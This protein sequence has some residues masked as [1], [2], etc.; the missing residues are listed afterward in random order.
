MGDEPASFHGKDKLFQR[1]FIPALKNF[2]LGQA[3]KRDIQL[4]RIQVLGIE[5]E[6]SSLGKVTGV[7]DPVPPVR[8]VVTARAY[9]ETRLRFR[10]RSSEF[11]VQKRHVNDE[12]KVEL[13]QAESFEAKTSNTLS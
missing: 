1:S 2:F 10:I 9:K 3:I 5:L 7:E 6:P 12:L 4:H 13:P 8:I 11:G